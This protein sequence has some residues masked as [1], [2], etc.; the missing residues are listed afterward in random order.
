MNETAITLR[1]VAILLS[2]SDTE[3]FVLPF[4][5]EARKLKYC[6]RLFGKE[7]NK[8]ILT[9]EEVSFRVKRVYRLFLP[10]LYTNRKEKIA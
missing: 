8:F 5:Q 6:S 7:N 2:G 1:K 3:F 4:Q 9:A 10:A